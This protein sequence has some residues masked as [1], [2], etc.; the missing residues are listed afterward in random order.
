MH[1]THDL[2]LLTRPYPFKVS[3]IF[4]QCQAKDHAFNSLVSG[5]V[6][7]EECKEFKIYVSAVIGIG[8]V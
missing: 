5:V 1:P 6:F 7:W 2:S 4:Q 3:T 8:K